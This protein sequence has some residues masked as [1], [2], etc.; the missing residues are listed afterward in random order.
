MRFLPFPLIN[1]LLHQVMDLFLSN[2]ELNSI[3][4]VLSMH[5]VIEHLAFHVAFRVGGV[6]AFI[7]VFPEEIRDRFFPRC[8]YGC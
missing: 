5:G 7:L 3:Q 2:L 6:D 8:L 4:K 1:S